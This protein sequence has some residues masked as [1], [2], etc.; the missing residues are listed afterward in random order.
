MVALVAVVV[1]ACGGGGKPGAE[2]VRYI[3]QSDAI[4]TDVFAK[5]AAAGN[6]HDQATAQ[7]QAD[8]WQDA[9]NR[10]GA[11]VPPSE[12]VELARQFTTGVQNISFGYSAAAQALAVGDQARADK[13]FNEVA[14]SKK[15]AASTAKDYGYNECTKING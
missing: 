4:C 13:S 11:M 7:K 1:A 9:A 3:T 5:A 12:S 14:A 15:Q 2:K 6:G 8:L 10:L